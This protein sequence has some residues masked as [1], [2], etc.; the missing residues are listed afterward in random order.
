AGCTEQKLQEI[1]EPKVPAA[2]AR[3]KGSHELGLCERYNVGS[4]RHPE[5]CRKPCLF[6]ERGECENGAACGYCHFQHLR[7]PAVPDRCQRSLIRRLSIPARF[8][9]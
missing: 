5:L 9:G 1:S 4:L 3:S 8:K 7:R 2:P 6:H